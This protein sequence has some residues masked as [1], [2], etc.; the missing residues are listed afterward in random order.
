[1]LIMLPAEEAYFL[2][3]IF[4]RGAVGMTGNFNTLKFAELCLTVMAANSKPETSF[5]HTKRIEKIVG[6]ILA[7]SYYSL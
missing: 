1:M 2:E 3:S 7:R 6:V 5:L 4:T